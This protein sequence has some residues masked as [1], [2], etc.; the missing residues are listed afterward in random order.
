[1]LSEAALPISTSLRAILQ[2]LASYLRHKLNYTL[3]NTPYREIR[4]CADPV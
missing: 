3:S 4:H 1:L 2:R